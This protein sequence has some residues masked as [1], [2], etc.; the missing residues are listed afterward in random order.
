MTAEV[1]QAEGRGWFGWLGRLRVQERR[2]F[3]AAFGGNALDN[4]D[5]SIFTFLIPTLIAV[6]GMSRG[7]AGL[8]ATSALVSGALGGWLTGI[9]ADRF[10]RVRVLQLTILWFS[11][12]TF[13]CG[14]AQTPEQMLI[15]R[16]LQGLGFGGELAVG[17]VL[18]GEAVRP[19]YRGRIMGGGWRAVSM[20]ERWA[21]APYSP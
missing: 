2:T 12:F 10:G 8:I 21:P 14:F 13:L 20:W 11:F 16:V 19:E 6:W 18:V 4:L 7:E 9:L 15:C 17:A 1:Q 5:V 3:V